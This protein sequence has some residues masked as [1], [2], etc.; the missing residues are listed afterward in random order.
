[1]NRPRHLSSPHDEQGA[2]GY[3]VLWLIGVPA[4]LLFLVFLLRGC[5]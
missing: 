5:T 2:I 4:S 1:M 3:I